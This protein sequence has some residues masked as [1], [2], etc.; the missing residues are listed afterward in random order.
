[1]HLSLFTKLCIVAG[2]VVIVPLAGAVAYQGSH[3][4]RVYPGVAVGTVPVGG[5]TPVE[6]ASAVSTGLTTSLSSQL[7]LTDGSKVWTVPLSDLGLHYDTFGAVDKAMLTGRSSSAPFE[8]VSQFGPVVDHPSIPLSVSIDQAK[9][10]AEVAKVAAGE[11]IPVRDAGITLDGATIQVTPSQSGR[12]VDEQALT[13]ILTERLS[14][15]DL[16]PVNIPLTI[17]RPA[18]VDGDVSE[19]VTQATLWV[20]QDVVLQTPIGPATMSKEA[21]AS[22]I[23]IEQPGGQSHA[24]ASIDMTALQNLLAP[25]AHQLE[26][27]PREA[28]FALVSGKLVVVSPGVTG[29]SLNVAATAEAIQQN[30]ESGKYMVPVV[31]TNS[32]PALL[33][34]ADVASLQAEL[35]RVTTTPLTVKTPNKQWTLS[36]ADLAGLIQLNSSLDESGAPKLALSLNM[37]M[38]Q[39][40]VASYAK[41]A[42]QV[43]IDAKVT[44]TNGKLATSTS[45]QDGITVDQTAAVQGLLAAME[46]TARTYA[47]PATVQPAKISQTTLAS[48]GITDVIATGTSN[49]AYSPPER[50]VNIKRGSQL[51]NDTLIAPDQV[52]SFDDTVG[53]IST[54][55][56]FDT[57]LIIADHRT[58]EGVGGGICQVSTTVFRA[59]LWAGLPI[60]ERHDHAY[61]VPY[62]TQGGYPEGFDATIF[63]PQL[64][65]KF[66]ND[67]GAYMLIEVSVD[68]STAN[69]AVTLYGTP[70][71]RKVQLVD[72]PIYNVKPHPADLRQ[73]DPTLPKG[74]VKQVDWSHDGFDTYINRVVTLNGNVTSRDTFK[75]HA[76][77]WQAV[78]L[79]GTGT[80]S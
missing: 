3:I 51:I 35:S 25:L 47:L 50:I 59:A 39:S 79:I 5:M 67:T 30:L 68:T 71:G 38:A 62:Y 72:G 74:V 27:A 56:G 44:W 36:P 49:F 17:T 4:G 48:L 8:L 52:F 40:L 6:A 26:L 2:I 34:L 16:S 12:Q 65:L 42:N 77:P 58:A 15:I 29:R 28:S 7:T 37:P 22:V 73:P 41:E 78:Y 23:R 54:D 32:R 14:R 19:A 64:D 63:S 66:K 60:V 11:Y 9:M 13:A 21:V 24:V 46:G 76:D 20:A 43:P 69:M 55:T 45:S 80:A 53:E 57:G 10:Q 75:T 33:G 70:T 1:M 18:T 61:A 31:T